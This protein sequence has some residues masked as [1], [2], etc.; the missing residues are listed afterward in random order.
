VYVLTDSEIAYVE[1]LRA[2][3]AARRAAKAEAAKSVKQ[4]AES[5]LKPEIAEPQ[6]PYARGPLPAT[7][8]GASKLTDARTVLLDHS[9]RIM[10][11]RP[12]N[13]RG[14]HE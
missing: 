13:K 12:S 11:G 10:P 2:R 4:K 3:E 6:L 8:S 14:R 9:S 1:R 7:G 5:D